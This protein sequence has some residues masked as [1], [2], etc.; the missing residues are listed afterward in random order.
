M[1]TRL[2]KQR[3]VAE[4]NIT[5]FTDVILVL[6]VIFMITTP[7]ISESNIRVKLP[8]SL[9]EQNGPGAESSQSIITITREGPVYLGSELVTKTELK[10]KI[11]VLS[12]N[13]P[14]LTVTVRSDKLVHFKDVVTVLDLLSE[15]GITK[16]D[17]ATI[18]GE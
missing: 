6:L 3:L 18:K 1:K 7:L 5:P 16:L 2:R 11:Q 8:E 13:N 17:I 10:S 9:S 15:L 14:N 12:K 4:I